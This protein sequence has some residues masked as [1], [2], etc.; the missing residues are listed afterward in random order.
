MQ[1][2]SSPNPRE[3]ID[4]EDVDPWSQKSKFHDYL[5]GHD[6]VDS[7]KT[8][9]EGKYSS[10]KSGFEKYAQEETSRNSSQKHHDSDHHASSSSRHD[11]G[12]KHSFSKR[13]STKHSSFKHYGSSSSSS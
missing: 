8:P 11:D 9:K 2:A 10:S 13:T 6:G 12:S 1:A 3:Q 4:F 5:D 7:L